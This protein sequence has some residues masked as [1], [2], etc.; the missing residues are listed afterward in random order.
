MAEDEKNVNEETEAEGPC[1][2]HDRLELVAA[3]EQGQRQR[4]ADDAQQCASQRGLREV[5]NR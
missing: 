1:V 3:S 2:L 5:G 4:D